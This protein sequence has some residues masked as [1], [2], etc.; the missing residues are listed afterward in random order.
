MKLV[1][2]KDY[3]FIAEEEFRVKEVVKERTCFMVKIYNDLY[4]RDYDRTLY[5]NFFNVVSEI[6]LEK[7]ISQYASLYLP[8]HRSRVV[9]KKQDL[10]TDSPSCA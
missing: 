6:D 3:W 9:Y 8:N 7:I 5:L 1:E 2:N 10:I 4:H